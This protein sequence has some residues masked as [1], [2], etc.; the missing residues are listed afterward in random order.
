MAFQVSG[1][2]ILY[3]SSGADIKKC[4]FKGIWNYGM[5][6]SIFVMKLF[7]SCEE[8]HIGWVDWHLTYRGY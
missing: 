5:V 3:S 6:A 2:L 8:A 1:G 7:S 4:I